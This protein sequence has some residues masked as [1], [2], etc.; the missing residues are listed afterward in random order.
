MMDKETNTNF[1][2]PNNDKG[3]VLRLEWQNLTQQHGLGT[4]WGCSSLQQWTCDHGGQVGHD[5][6]LRAK[7]ALAC[8]GQSTA[9][10]LAPFCFT[11]VR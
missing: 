3:K 9:Q 10:V 7:E 5:P 4:A 11:P 1:V 6:E 8:I 2:W